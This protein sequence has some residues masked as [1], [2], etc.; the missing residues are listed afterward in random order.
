MALTHISS[1]K[2]AFVFTGSVEPRY[3]ADVR[4]VLET[5]ILYY[6]YEPANIDVVSSVAIPDF[7]FTGDP[8]PEN[9]FQTDGLTNIVIGGTDA[10]EM[11]DDL[12]AKLAAFTLSASSEIE[13]GY[14]NNVLLYFTGI[15][16]YTTTGATLY[17]LEIGTI[18]ATP[19]TIT[20]N[21]LTAT[22]A[23]DP[24]WLQAGMVNIVMQ[25]S[26]AYGFYSG[27]G[28]IN[29]ISGTGIELSFTAACDTGVNAAGTDDGS[30]FTDYWVMGLR[31]GPRTLSGADHFA[32]QEVT[33]ATTPEPVDNHL[34]SLR[35]AFVY[36]KALI[37]VAQAPR[38]EEM[39]TEIKYLGLPSFIIRDGDDTDP[40]MPW[41]ESPDIYLTHADDPDTPTDLYLADEENIIH[42]LV[43]NQGTHPVREFWV[44]SI[45]FHSGGGGGGDTAA[46]IETVILKPG[47]IYEHEYSYS[48]PT[49]IGG[50]S[51]THRCIRAKAQLEEI[52][53]EEMDQDGVDDVAWYVTGRDSEAQ[54]NLDKMVVVPSPAPAPA[55]GT[56]NVDEQNPGAEADPPD[57]PADPDE[58]ETEGA[59]SLRNLRGYFEHIY[60]IRNIFKK[61][62]KFMII[63]PDEYF[64]A[65]KLYRIEWFDITGDRQRKPV[66]LKIVTKPVPSVQLEIEPGA[67]MNIM[68]Y[69]ALRKGV[70]YNGALRIPF[71]IALETRPLVKELQKILKVN[72]LSTRIP[73]HAGFGGITVDIEI[74]RGGSV[75]GLLS[76]FDGKPLPGTNLFIST[77]NGRQSAVVR[78]DKNGYYSV[79]NINPDYYRLKLKTKE[80]RSKALSFM[81]GQGQ[82][83]RCD[84]KLDRKEKRA[85]VK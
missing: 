83:V 77:A 11:Q 35:K 54:R 22:L 48:F 39:G 27:T 76:D 30:D 55:P 69:I 6:G 50:T 71:E 51:V 61:K 56:G 12:A 19:V 21:W 14:R 46:F 84:I 85:G 31:L 4:K 59:R 79:K 25:Q 72:D 1:N 18:G 16:T 52:V 2:L 29:I 58:Q 23:A 20:Q 47:D 17:R 74:G 60:V 73:D 66:R 80:G 82:V 63:M 40:P 67:E 7:T 9:I 41:W 15:G 10:S 26:Y 33:D 3:L 49:D 81:L 53:T 13:A 75:Y 57:E 32:D 44:G 34:V 68:M 8:D 37:A 45:V 28:G 65:E 38:Y 78:S 43:Q 5:L 64:R 36:A 42:V 24:S 70:R 62:R